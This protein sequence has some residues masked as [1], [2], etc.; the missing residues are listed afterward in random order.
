MVKGFLELQSW[1]GFVP[2]A[3]H[4]MGRLKIK[5]QDEVQIEHTLTKAEAKQLTRD[6]RRDG[7][8]PFVWSAG[9]T[10]NRFITEEAVIA[11]AIEV[12]TELGVTHLF[13]GSSCTCDPQKM[14]IGPEPIKT[15]LNRLWER[16]E[17]NDGWEG[18]EKTMKTICAEWEELI[19][20]Q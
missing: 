13:L 1:S 17:A 19:P 7:E 20:W 12:A 16:A 2:G 4:F 14:L 3:S 11:R 8:R 9:D 15:A 18:D 6:D 10:S 5:G